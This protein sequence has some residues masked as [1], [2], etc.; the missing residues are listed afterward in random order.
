[1]QRFREQ[2]AQIEEMAR[3]F[4]DASFKKLRSAEGAFD[5]LQNVR[6]VKSRESINRQLM[7]KWYEI[8]DQYS[9]EVDAIGEIFRTNWQVCFYYVL[10]ANMSNVVPDAVKIRPLQRINQKLL[11]LLPGRVL[12]LEESKRPL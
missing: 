6:S 9:R 3:S 2:T 8:L 12:C 11:G 5:L 10:Q 7:T 4:L 1:M